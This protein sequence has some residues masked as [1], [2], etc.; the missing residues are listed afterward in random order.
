MNFKASFGIKSIVRDW[1][2]LMNDTK[3]YVANVP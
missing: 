1:F 3:M 2:T